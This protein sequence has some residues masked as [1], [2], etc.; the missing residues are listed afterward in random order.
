MTA[1]PDP[2]KHHHHHN[3][4]HLFRSLEKSRSSSPK[5][6]GKLF[7]RDS[8]HRLPAA[9]AD[10]AS[11]TPSTKAAAKDNAPEPSSSSVL[12]ALLVLL[13]RRNDTNTRLGA[14]RAGDRVKPRRSETI[15]HLHRQASP[16]PLPKSSLAFSGKPAHEKIKYNPYGINKLVLNEPR[17]STL[18]YLT[19]GADAGGRVVANPVA[20]P[21]AYLPESL[22]QNHVNLLDDFEFENA[23][24]KVGDGGS[25]EVRIVSLNAN[26]KKLYALKKFSLFAKES[27]EEFYKRAAK[28]YIISRRVSDLRHV[29]TTIALLRVQSQGHTTRGWGMLMSLCDGG[30]LFSIIVKLGWKRALLPERYCLF[31]QIAYGLKYLHDHDVAHRDLKPEN[32][33][34][35]RNGMAQICDFGV[36]DYGHEEPGNFDSPLHLS[37]SYVGSPPYSPPEVM[38]LKE[39]LVTEAKKHPYNPFKMDYWGLGMLLFCLIYAGVPFQQSSVHDS[40]YRDYK[41][42]RDRY[43]SDNP[44]F[45]NSEDYSRGPGSE[46]KWAAQF[47]ST[48]AARVAW[49]LCDPS[50]SS[51]YDLDMLF[52]DTWFKELE[53]CVYEHPDQHVDPFIFNDRSQSTTSSSFSGSHTPTRKNTFSG[54]NDSDTGLHTPFRSMLDLSGAGAVVH[55]DSQDLDHANAD[56]A[57]IKSSSL[58]THIPL[59]LAHGDLHRKHPS[60]ENSFTNEPPHLN[61]APVPRV[62]S[63]LDFGGEKLPLTTVS[64]LKQCN[65]FDLSPTTETANS[66]VTKKSPSPLPIVEEADSTDAGDHSEKAPLDAATTDVDPDAQKVEPGNSTAKGADGTATSEKEDAESSEPNFLHEEPLHGSNDLKFDNNGNCELGYKVKK[67]HHLDISNAHIGGTIS[68]R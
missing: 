57:S 60:R 55:L 17:H 3:I 16:L 58:L 37:Y 33:L 1:T 18:F 28:E 13:L 49:K 9:P 47:H 21:N 10:S 43:I 53:M 59:T 15:S 25:G 45:K 38:M 64:E 51:R 30:D 4:K 19:G 22:H 5:G 35:D 11:S 56:N 54:R 63:M 31:K 14:A 52:K 32:I 7:K 42:S 39:M 68:R 44:S 67:H 34:L 6:I 23:D 24:K 12:R 62:R 29:V 41:F 36:S 65:E 2:E 40:H 61:P 48:G 27:D 26:R 46:F 8:H 50:V 20:D 66:E